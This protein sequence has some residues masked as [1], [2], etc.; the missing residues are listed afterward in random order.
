MG[1][2]AGCGGDSSG[3]TF[4]SSVVSIV[5]EVLVP[6][7]DRICHVRGTVVNTGSDVAVTVVMRWQAFD[8]S[9]AAIATTRLTVSGVA[10]GTQVGF[11]STG[12]ASNDR[13]LV[14]CS[15]I[16]R[17]ERIETTIGPA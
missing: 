5:D 11:E 10:P 15:D 2:L 14:G 6:V 8:A 12:F 4:D 3:P 13:G 1:L 16:A 7:T 17:F 9:D